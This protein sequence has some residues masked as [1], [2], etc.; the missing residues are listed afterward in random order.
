MLGKLN[1]KYYIIFF[2]NTVLNITVLWVTSVL[3]FLLLP[4]MKPKINYITQLKAVSHSEMQSVKGS[5]K[6]H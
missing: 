6:L 2:T 3:L 4:W 5:I 1:Y